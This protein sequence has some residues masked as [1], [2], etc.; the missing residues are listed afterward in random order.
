MLYFVYPFSRICIL[1]GSNSED[2]RGEREG[3]ISYVVYFC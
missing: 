3:S 2:F 1:S